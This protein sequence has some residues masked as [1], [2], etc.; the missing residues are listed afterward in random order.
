MYLYLFLG[1]PLWQT[2][3]TRL[4]KKPV[5]HFGSFSLPTAQQQI[6]HQVLVTPT[7]QSLQ[8]LLFLYMD[9]YVKLD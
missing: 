3:P 8:S 4:Y 1:S 5:G 2:A 7:L 9:V 6:S